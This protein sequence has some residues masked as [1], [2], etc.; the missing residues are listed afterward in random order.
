M[1]DR[2][3]LE[4]LVAL[5]YPRRCPVCGEI[6]ASAEGMIHPGC[7]KRLMPVRQPVCQRCGRGLLNDQQEYCETCRKRPRSFDGGGSLLV[8]NEAARHSMAAVKYKN[9]REYLDF[10]AEAMDVRYG[11]KVK[12]W[13]PDCLIPV[14]VHKKRLRERGFNQ[15]EELAVRLSRR[16]EIPTESLLVRCKQTLPQR[17]LDPAERAK[18]L[19]GAFAV[20]QERVGAPENAGFPANVL[21]IDDIYTTGATI[22]ACARVLKAAGAKQ[23]YFLTIC[24]GGTV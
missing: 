12:F 15:A 21:L 1:T 20:R 13:N 19:H 6:V 18:N 17:E 9:R 4:P 2:N 10:Y 8:Y 7:V 22:E 5:L 24:T 14:P 23:V 16:W 3:K 11:K